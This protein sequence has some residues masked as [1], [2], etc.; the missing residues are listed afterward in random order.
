MTALARSSRFCESD[1]ALEGVTELAF[2]PRCNVAA[3][4]DRT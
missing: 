1:L 2:R 3:D 4:C